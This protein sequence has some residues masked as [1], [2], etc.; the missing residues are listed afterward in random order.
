[1]IK[2]NTNFRVEVKIENILGDGKTI[3]LYGLFKFTDSIKGLKKAIAD[4]INSSQQYVRDE[5]EHEH[6]GDKPRTIMTS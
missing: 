4:L 3:G 1:M 2:I 6:D 5:I